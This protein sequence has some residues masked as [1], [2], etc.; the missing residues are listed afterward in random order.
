MAKTNFTKVEKALNEGLTQ[1]TVSK[2]LDLA[3]S[4]AASMGKGDSKL[5]LPSQEQRSVLF[6]H[7]EQDLKKLHNEN[8]TAY[9]SVSY[10]KDTL[11][12]LISN[13]ETL[14]SA[15]WKQVKEIKEKVEEF[16]KEIAKKL[17]QNSDEEIVEDQRKEHINKRFNV[18]KTWLPLK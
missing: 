1:I 17:P 8:L 18:R 3:D 2:L 5:H 11:K 12:R 9:Q 16:K 6:Q 10:I 4:T 15:E 13:P 7:L 14:T